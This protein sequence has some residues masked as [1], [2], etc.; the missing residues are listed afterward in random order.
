MHGRI[1]GVWLVP[2]STGLFTKTDTSE[3]QYPS[4]ARQA[5]RPCCL[6]LLDANPKGAED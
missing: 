2:S 1:L 6:L 4:K 5:G 3:H